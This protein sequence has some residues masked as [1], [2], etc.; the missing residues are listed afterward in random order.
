MLVRWEADEAVG[1]NILS[2]Y[3]PDKLYHSYMVLGANE[4]IIGALMKGEPVYVRVDAFNEQGIT[5][6]EVFAL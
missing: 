5:E 3:A 2:G 4:K 6:G 1:H